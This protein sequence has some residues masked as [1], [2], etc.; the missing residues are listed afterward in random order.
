MDWSLA[1]GKERE[2]SKIILRIFFH[3]EELVE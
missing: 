3:E 1:R 2:V